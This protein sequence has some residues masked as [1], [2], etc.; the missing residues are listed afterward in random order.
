M[1]EKPKGKNINGNLEEKRRRALENLAKAREAKKAKLQS[2]H[3]DIY[4]EDSDSDSDSESD[5][6]FELIPVK[7]K[8]KGKSKP[9]KDNDNVNQKLDMLENAIKQM[10]NKKPKKSKPKTQP[11]IN[12]INIPVQEPKKEQKQKTNDDLIMEAIRKQILG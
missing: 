11:I 6:E 3:N 2:A 10:M 9:N 5:S 7:N 12:N 8:S 1:S 4:E